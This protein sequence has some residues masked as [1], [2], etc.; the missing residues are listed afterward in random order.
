MLLQFSEVTDE[1]LENIVEEMTRKFLSRG[2]GMLRHILGD[3]GIKVQRM[4]LCNSIQ[5]VD[6]EGVE[7]GNNVQGVNN[8]WH[9][10]TNHR[11]DNAIHRTNHYIEICFVN[12]YPRDSD[13]MDSVIPP[14]KNRS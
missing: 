11:M 1:D 13:S 7:N 4:R 10:D 14:S 8:L 2:E 5:K 12:T 9:V 6:Y 3:R